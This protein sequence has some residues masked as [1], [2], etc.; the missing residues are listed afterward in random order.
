MD[1]S[2]HPFDERGEALAKLLRE[3]IVFLDG[4]MGTLIQGEGLAEADF[5]GAHPALQSCKI[6]LLGN[7]DLLNLSRPEVLYKLHKAYYI[8]GADI[9]TTNTFNATSI[10]QADYGLQPL[11]REINLAA[12]RLVRGIADEIEREFPSRKC[13]VAGSLGP[14]NKSSSMSP[15]VANPALRSVTFD[16]L[17]ASYREQLEALWDGG[18]DIFLLETVFDTLNAKAA[19][20]AYLTLVEERGVRKPIAI[21]ATISD[22][23]GRVLCGQTVEAFYASVR[24]AHPLFVG[25]NCGLG[26]EKMRPYIE[27]FNDVADCYTHCY[28]NAGLPNPLSKYGYDQGPEETA[29]YLKQ[30]A[31]EG[32]LNV[33]GGCCG[34]TP[35]HIAAVVEACKAY[36]PRLPKPPSKDFCVSGLDLFKLPEKNAPFMLIGE[37]A[38]VMGSI[39]FRKMIKADDYDSALIV[40]RTQIENG[41]NAIDINFDEAMLDS[42]ACMRR[43]L[44]LAAGEPEI[45]K[46]PFV[47]DSSDWETVLAGLKCL[48]GKA[49]VNSISLKEGEDLFLYRA[50]EI[51]KFGAA[52]VVMAFDEN[53]QASETADKVKICKRAY[54][55]LTQRLG[56]PAQDIIFDANVLTVGTGIEEHNP[57]AVNFIEAVRQIKIEC[58]LAR[59]SAGVSNISFSFR[60]NNPVREAMHSVFLYHAINA[61]LDMGIVNAGVLPPYD[62]IEPRLKKLVEDVVLNVSPAATEALLA[63]ADSFKG[64]ARNAS[65]ESVDDWDSLSWHDKLL[66]CFVKGREE[67]VEE[68]V[69]HYYAQLG[70]AIKV[71][72]GPLMSGMKH[73]GKL[74]GEGKMFLP[75][76]VKSAR[77]MKKAV[78]ILEPL[79]PKASADRPSNVKKVVMATVKGDVHDIGKN[80]VG[81]VLGCNN[82][83]VIDL[84]VMCPAEK[85]LEAAKTHKADVVGLSGLITPSLEEMG[86]IAALFEREGMNVPIIVG[87]ATTSRL[88][89]AVKIAPLYSGCIERVADA[90]LVAGVCADLCDDARLKVFKS[91]VKEEHTK[92][93]EDFLSGKNYE[94]KPKL[95][96]IKEARGRALKCVFDKAEIP[97]PKAFGV[98][99]EEVPFA[100]I[101]E[102]IN[103]TPF[104]HAWEFKGSYPRILSDPQKGVEASKF[105]EEAMAV[106]EKMKSAL[107]PRIAYGFFEANSN[108]DDVV[109]YDA[110]GGVLDTLYLFR[111]QKD[112]GENAPSL[113]MADFVAP[114]GAGFKDV[115]GLFCASAGAES[116]AFIE[117][118]DPARKSYEALLAQTLC[119]RV[120]EASAE[121]LHHEKFAP[122]SKH[123]G[124]RPA[125][126][127]PVYPDHAEKARLWKLL[128]VQSGIGAVITENFAMKPPS[129]VCGAW[130]AHKDSKY[131]DL[132]RLG[133][134]QLEDYAMR[135][136]IALESIKQF[137]ANGGAIMDL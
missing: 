119:D 79:M 105:F 30:Y 74:F 109:L 125:M 41:A 3:R 84:G 92:L 76:V 37:R 96:S 13:F 81:V 28:P 90:S 71:V 15:D 34:T 58:P 29:S 32:L 31:E 23:A 103:F 131:F 93:R 16:E 63:A 126:G 77:V 26:A 22:A 101:E 40:A 99:Y 35:K 68:V 94:D 50:N 2:K 78:A 91:K 61:G 107:K 45:S 86:K 39:A 43:F 106:F 124:V 108:G 113:C 88:H 110:K 18:A 133:K 24:Q 9:V 20:Y 36:K 11:V 129:T 73:V 116:E 47:I 130:F 118:L 69:K 55:L 87:G 100:K 27:I 33:I 95:L 14:M 66:R 10:V 21:S 114:A 75:Q 4:G 12:A 85:I 97:Q 49:I 123:H 117:S 98:F 6:D 57:Y 8:A 64:D 60:G 54:K 7:S 72:E 65:A 135:K 19:I 102:Y 128:N 44:N 136:G 89:T 51:K 59:T 53:G 42:K 17:A 137:I 48:Q 62:D 52:M 132:G 82:Y 121:Y 120:A 127:Y 111:S 67:K 115:V 83:E 70:E 134:D 56:V 80:I 5:R 25:L 104:F 1:I 122:I 38:N 112:G 46:A